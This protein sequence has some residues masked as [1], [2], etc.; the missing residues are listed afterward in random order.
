VIHVPRLRAHQLERLWFRGIFDNSGNSFPTD[1][2][3]VL[4]ETI[5]VLKD[6]VIYDLP[7]HLAD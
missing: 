2:R 5:E 4:V 3:K 6:G 1:N 7:P